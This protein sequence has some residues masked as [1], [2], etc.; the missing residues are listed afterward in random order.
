[1]ADLRIETAQNIGIDYT[2]ATI[3]DRILATILDGLI[4]IG[5]LVFMGLLFSTYTLQITT[6]LMVILIMFPLFIY[7]P[8]FEI[9]LQ[10]QSPGKKIM[11]TRVMKADGTEA[12]IGGYLL[13][14]LLGIIEIQAFTGSIA[15]ITIIVSGKGQR[16]GDMAA[17]TTVVKLKKEMSLHDTMLTAVEENYKPLFHQVERLSDRDI[18]MIKNIID[19]TGRHYDWNTYEKLA[20]ELKSVLEQ[21][22]D[23]RS[24]LQPFAFLATV[25]KDYNHLAGRLN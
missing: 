25:L 10:G 6:G 24:E 7:H 4:M 5:Y 22:M 3:S 21:K 8:F 2:I 16:L 13:R 15:L 12:G 20:S 19:R 11:N 9:M 1:M 17:G 23:I 14:W 18:N